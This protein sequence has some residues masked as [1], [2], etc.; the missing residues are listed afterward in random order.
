MQVKTMIHIAILIIQWSGINTFAKNYKK[1]EQQTPTSPTN[2][3]QFNP[4]W[5]KA[6]VTGGLPDEKKVKTIRLISPS[7]NLQ[8]AISSLAKDGGGVILLKAGEY[9]ISSTIKLESGVILRGCNKDSVLL[10]VKIHGHHFSTGK[11][12]QS[13]LYIGN[14]HLVGIENLTLKYT[15]A[16]FEPMDKDSL[17]SPWEKAVFHVRELRD[18]TLFVE[19]IWIDGS[20]NCWVKN[21]KLLW[22]GNDPILITNSKYITCCHNYIDR[23]YNKCDGGMGYYDLTNSSYVLIHHEK[24]RR[25]RHFAI[26]KGSRNNVIINNY[27]EVDVNFHD[28]DQGNNL[29]GGNTIRIPEWHSWHCFSRGDPNQHRPPGENNILF[30]ND[31][32][33]KTGKAELS[34]TNQAYLINSIWPGG[35][36]FPIDIK[37]SDKKKL[38][39]IIHDPYPN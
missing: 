35:K 31:A 15:G 36:A 27:L 13:A 9:I 19:H 4:E 25:I 21:C 37:K 24:I 5:E 11:P 8:Q 39:H 12:R 10:S 3:F 32:I 26:Q 18:T 30:N 2:H 17:S 6:G 29:I 28:G 33:D 38:K 1:A 14:K 22:A 23:S 34:E 7:E 16:S 20:E